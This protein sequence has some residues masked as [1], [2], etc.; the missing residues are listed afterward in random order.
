MNP[1]LTS[2]HKKK[3]ALPCTF[4]QDT[5]GGICLKLLKN[6]SHERPVLRLG[7]NLLVLPPAEVRSSDK[8]LQGIKASKSHLLSKSPVH[9]AICDEKYVTSYAAGLSYDMLDTAP[10]LDMR[11]TNSWPVQSQNSGKIYCAYTSCVC[12]RGALWS[13]VAQAD[14]LKCALS[15]TVVRVV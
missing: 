13:M 5:A 6:K 4:Q 11:V 1:I 10:V 3:T 14:E 12:I 8:C 15:R 7:P 2:L 9:T